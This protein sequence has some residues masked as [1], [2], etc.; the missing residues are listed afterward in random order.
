M[1]CRGF[2]VGIVLVLLVAVTE[3]R[4]LYVAPGGDDASPGTDS[5]YPVATWRKAHDAAGAG[6]TIYVR[7]GTYTTGTGGTG[8]TITKSGTSGNP[9]RFRA[10]PGESPVLDCSSLQSS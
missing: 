3:G 8:V 10:Y 9:I 4:I 7:G 1:E 5:R 6:D 2:V